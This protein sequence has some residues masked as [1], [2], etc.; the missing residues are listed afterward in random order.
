LFLRLQHS[1]RRHPRDF[2]AGYQGYR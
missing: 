1:L 2:T